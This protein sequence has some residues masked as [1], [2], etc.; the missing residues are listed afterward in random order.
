MEAKIIKNDAEH[1]AAL[2]M[3]AGLMSA[4]PGTPQA[5]ALELWSFLVKD[6]EKRVY[7]IGLPDPI[8]AIRFRMEQAGLKACDLEL[9]LG[10]KSKVSEVLNRKRTLSLT[11]IRKLHE[12]LGIPAEVLL[13]KP[14]V[15]SSEGGHGGLYGRHEHN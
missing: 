5:E 9:Y 3:V 11:M 15:T 10:G 8:D 6:Y 2:E 4:K 13:R 1:E 7:P 12:G 14:G